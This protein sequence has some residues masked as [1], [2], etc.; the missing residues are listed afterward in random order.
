M[1]PIRQRLRAAILL[2]VPACG[3]GAPAPSA[4]VAAPPPAGQATLALRA[5]ALSPDNADLQRDAARQLMRDGQY[6]L[7]E[8]FLAVAADRIPGGEGWQWLGEAKLRLGD[9]DGALRAWLRA[10]RAGRR[11]PGLDEGLSRLERL[12]LHEG[13]LWLLPSGEWRQDGRTLF[14][15]L[16]RQ[17][18]KISPAGEDA[19]QSVRNALRG[20]IPNAPEMTVSTEPDGVRTACVG[21]EALRFCAA[22]RARGGQALTVVGDGPVS[23]TRDALAALW[24]HLLST[25]GD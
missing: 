22:S 10:V 6:R 25:D 13:T 5:A 2:I 15:P 9:D 16:L 1:Y 24:P 4:G 21:P 8:D 18:A 3:I 23:Q 12:A 14:N 20:L 11:D 7:A 17:R 19:A